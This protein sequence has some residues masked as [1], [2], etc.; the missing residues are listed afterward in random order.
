MKHIRAGSGSSGTG[1]L[2]YDVLKTYEGKK[3]NIKTVMGGGKEDFDVVLKKDVDVKDQELIGVSPYNN[4]GVSYYK[5][6]PDGD[7]EGKDGQ[8]VSWAKVAQ[9]NLDKTSANEAKRGR[10]TLTADKTKS[11]SNEIHVSDVPTGTKL[12]QKNGKYYYKGQEVKM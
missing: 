2:N 3:T 11:T 8:V 9:A 1:L 5:V 7:W 10:T 12:E 4:G 6:R